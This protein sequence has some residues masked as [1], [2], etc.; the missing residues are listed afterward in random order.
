VGEKMT[1]YRVIDFDDETDE[2]VVVYTHEDQENRIIVPAVI[3]DDG[4]TVDVVASKDAIQKAIREVIKPVVKTVKRFGRDLVGT[5]D[6]L[7][8][9][10]GGD[11]SGLLDPDDFIAAVASDA[12]N[13]D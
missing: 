13:A 4:E 3:E 1:E 10:P 8:Q 12:V 6:T 11:E 7:Q 9:N 2:Y 5:T